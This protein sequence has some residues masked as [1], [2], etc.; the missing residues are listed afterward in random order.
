MGTDKETVLCGTPTGCDRPIV[1][2]H[3]GRKAS[4][5]LHNLSHPGVRVAI[6]LT[7]ERFC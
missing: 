2:K 7:A 6:E 5:T 4:N 3:Y 1:L